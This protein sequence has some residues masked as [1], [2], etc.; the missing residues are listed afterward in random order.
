MTPAI[1]YEAGE[2]TET[3]ERGEYHIK[4]NEF[5]VAYDNPDSKEGVESKVMVPTDRVVRID[6]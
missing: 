5:L 4:S 1:H 3:I 6:G 2:Q